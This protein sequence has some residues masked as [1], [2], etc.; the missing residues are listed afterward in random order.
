MHNHLVDFILKEKLIAKDEKVLL[1]V[2]GGIDSMVMCH[3]FAQTDF[4]FGIAHCNFALRGKESDGDALF[5]EALAKQYNIPFYLHNCDASAYAKKQKISIQMAAR[6]LRFAWFRELCEKED[7]A[8]YAT[9]HHADDAIETYFINQLRGTGIAGMHGLLPKNGKLIHPLLFTTRKEIDS[10]VEQNK[11]SYREDSS[12]KSVKYLRN[13]L[14][15]NVLPVLENI[16]PAYREIFM[17]NMERFS[18][19]ESIYLQKI[20]EEKKRICRK[21]KEDLLIAISELINLNSVSTYLY[22]FIKEF[23]FVFSQV[24]D[25]LESI[26]NGYSGAQFFSSTHVLLR[27]RDELI[28]TIKREEKR[29]VVELKNNEGEIHSPLFL[30]WETLK[31]FHIEK[32][33]HLAFL[34]VDKLKFPLKLRKWEQ[35]DTFYPLGMRGKKLVS[36]F[37]IDIKLNQFQKENVWL[38]LSN[39]EI[40]WIVGYRIDNRFRISTETKQALK[41]EVQY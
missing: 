28:L 6:D 34:D 1:A 4:S 36:D 7:Y 29:E 23:G 16:Q 33:A 15:H 37:F 38:L 22:E 27:D 19:A 3:L 17:Q 35:G 9:A 40:V 41:I 18:A 26:K 32:D 24:E 13:S 2:S 39:E 11:L 30:K 20:E 21:E 12:N 31:E 14:R 25:V 10:Y 5:V 8:V